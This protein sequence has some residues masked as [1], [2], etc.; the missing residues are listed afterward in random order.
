MNN[1]TQQN[2]Y[3]ARTRR[4]KCC[5]YCGEEILANAKKCKHCGEWL[6]DE[7]YYRVKQGENSEDWSEIW[8]N[9]AYLGGFLC[10][11]FAVLDFG[12]GTFGI[13]DITGVSWTP[14]LFCLF[15]YLLQTL[16]KSSP[17]FQD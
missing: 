15:G 3:K 17:K 8:P 9:L 6:V 7:S 1:T 16:A 14:P 12:L 11:V 10:Y 13:M 4:T 5:P 2:H